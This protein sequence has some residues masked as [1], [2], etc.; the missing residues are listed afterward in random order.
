MQR[1]VAI[2]LSLLLLAGLMS[3]A[4]AATS[5]VYKCFVPQGSLDNVFTYTLPVIFHYNP[6]NTPQNI[7][8]LRVYDSAGTKLFDQSYPVSST[9]GLNAPIPV[10]PF[11]SIQIG[12]TIPPTLPTV[13][14]VAEAL[15]GLQ[16]IVNWSQGLDK[17]IPIARADLFHFDV[18]VEPAEVFSVAQ[19]A[20]P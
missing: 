17:P 3:Q 7:T 11:G 20:C 18:S 4:Q 8:R 10:P 16:F 5:G 1:I 19:S 14:S 12:A 15:Q 9:P 2:S 13:D 6:N